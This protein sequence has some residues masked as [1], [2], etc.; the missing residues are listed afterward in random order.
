MEQK[1]SD[2]KISLATAVEIITVTEKV[3]GPG[4]LR[5][6]STQSGWGLGDSY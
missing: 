2:S 5:S 1:S 6:K 3:E 4:Q